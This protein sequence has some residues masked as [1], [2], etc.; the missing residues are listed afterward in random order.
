MRSERSE[1]RASLQVCGQGQVQWEVSQEQ[2][3]GAGII[4]APDKQL[5]C[6]CG[7]SH[8]SSVG[9]FATPWTVAHEAPPSMGFSRQGYWNAL[10]FSRVSSRPRDWTHISYISYIVRQVL[11]TP[12]VFK[13]CVVKE[14]RGGEKVKR[15]FLENER[16]KQK[17]PVEERE[18]IRSCGFEL[19]CKTKTYS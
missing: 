1:K 4:S 3:T 9:L 2:L 19:H 7:L 18:A 15:M 10:H 17:E 14:G 5:V 13:K 16:L 11:S 12:Y 6:A 8:F